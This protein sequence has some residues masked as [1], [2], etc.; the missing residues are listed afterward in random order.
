MLLVHGTAD[1]V[2]G[3]D[4]TKCYDVAQVDDT[5]QVTSPKS[6]EE[7][8]NKI[9]TSDKKLTLIEVCNLLLSCGVPLLRLRV[10]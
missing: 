10:L 9:D 8:Y 1:R 4:I 7:F 3:A 2:R 6:T 5:L